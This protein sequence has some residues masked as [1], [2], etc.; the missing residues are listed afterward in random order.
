MAIGAYGAPHPLLLLAIKDSLLQRGHALPEGDAEA[1]TK[2]TI[3]MNHD[4]PSG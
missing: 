1:S 3:D 2:N 4:K